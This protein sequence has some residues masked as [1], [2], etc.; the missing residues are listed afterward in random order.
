MYNKEKVYNVILKGGTNM[1]FAM[2]IFL[3]LGGL[4]CPLA[5]FFSDMFLD[6]LELH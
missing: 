6:I 2:I 5:A 1:S 4:V 3:F